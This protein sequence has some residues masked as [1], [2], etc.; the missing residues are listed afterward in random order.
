MLE[1]ISEEVITTIGQHGQSLNCYT[2]GAQRQRHRE[3]YLRGGV[4]ECCWCSVRVIRNS[5]YTYSYHYTYPST[6]AHLSC[7]PPAVFLP[8]LQMLCLWTKTEYMEYSVQAISGSHTHPVVNFVHYFVKGLQLEKIFFEVGRAQ[9][10][11]E[12]HAVQVHRLSVAV[13]TQCV[14]LLSIQHRWQ[15]RASVLGRHF[16]K[17]CLVKELAIHWYWLGEL[18]FYTALCLAKPALPRDRTV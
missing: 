3:L 9:N 15:V 7:K 16:E 11:G 13:K 6:H 17:G 8:W 1:G 5:T 14:L 4:G 18:L 2:G 12:D 10:I